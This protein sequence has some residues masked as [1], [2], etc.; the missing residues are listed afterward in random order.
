MNETE[1]TAIH[2]PAAPT[3][4]RLALLTGF[5]VAAS[6]IPLPFLPDR[7][8]V[9]VRGAIV[10]DVVARHA[11][12]LTTDARAA[13][14]KTSADAPMRDLVRKG[15]AVLSKTILKRLGPLALISTAAS[16]VEAYALGLLLEHYIE[17]HRPRG[18]VRIHAEEA[19]ELRDRIDRAI[20]RAV[21]PNLRPEPLPLLP[22]G[23][24][25]RDELTRWIDTVILAGASFPAYLER[26]LTSAFDE[27]TRESGSH[28]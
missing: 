18:A 17:H 27:I 19:R 15:I 23:E 24:D 2:S 4:G 13:L 7:V 11:L 10:Q 1:A 12:S 5:S 28:G 22:G 14:A 8:I 9:Q 25:L 6:A 21:S 3:T 26:R 20:V 16:G